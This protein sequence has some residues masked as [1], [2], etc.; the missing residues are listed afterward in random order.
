[1][2]NYVDD[3]RKMYMLISLSKKSIPYCKNQVATKGALI[4]T[5][6]KKRE[7]ELCSL[8]RRPELQSIMAATLFQ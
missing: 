2:P 1:M 8:S 3:R 4:Y 7:R 5:T 6:Y